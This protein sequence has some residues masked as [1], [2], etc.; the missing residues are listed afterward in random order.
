VRKPVLVVALVFIVALLV[1]VSFALVS[2]SGGS[3]GTSI[4][5]AP[6]LVPGASPYRANFAP[7]HL[8]DGHTEFWTVQLLSGDYF[9]LNGTGSREASAFAVRVLPAGTDD[10]TL[11]REIPVV[12]GSLNAITAFTA[13]QSGTYPIE[14]TCTMTARCTSV[15]LQ[16]TI[17]QDVLL[18]LPRSAEVGESG[19]FTVTVRT[20]EGAPVTSRRFVVD[21]YGVWEG[22]Y[23]TPTHYVLGSAYATDGKA[24]FTY[25]LPAGLAGETIYL[26]A[27]ATGP[28]YRPTSSALCQAKVT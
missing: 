24:T 23:S 26:Q 5:D 21:L 27:T 1:G 6:A 20:P 10:A 3:S 19:T 8:R 14:I 28:G 18:G 17:R 2:S 4:A 15:N 16:V 22:S 9:S 11:R 13:P 12:Q 25:T 7:D